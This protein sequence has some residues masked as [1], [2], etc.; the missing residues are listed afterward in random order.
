[1]DRILHNLN[2]L[3]LGDLTDEWVEGIYYAEFLEFGEFPSEYESILENIEIRSVFRK[4]MNSVDKWLNSIS[5]TSEEKTWAVLSHEVNHKKLLALLAY[6]IDYGGKNIMVQEHRNTALLASRVYFKLLSIPGY[7]AYHIYHSQ[8]FAQSLGC[9]SY[10]KT[11]CEN[12][13]N[14]FNLRQLTCEVNSV[15][16]E[17]ALFAQDLRA[18]IEALQLNPA[19]MNFEDILGN[20]VEFTGGAIVNKLDIGKNGGH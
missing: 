12:E 10:P 19:D 18:V 20:L 1:M 15:L 14:Y 11:L 13:D 8:L 4:I 9:L 3:R 16:K 17:V 6:Y 5:G 2:Y 7:K